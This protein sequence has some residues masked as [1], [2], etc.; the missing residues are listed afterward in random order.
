[1]S[2]R[3]LNLHTFATA[4]V[5]AATAVITL[6]VL[7]WPGVAA[8]PQAPLRIGVIDNHAPF[9]YMDGNERRGFD[10]EVAQAICARMKR[11]CTFVPLHFTLLL[12]SLS[13][14]DVDA[15][16]AGFK[17]TEQR[18]HEYLFSS[19]YYRSRSFFITDDK[20]I[21]DV[22]PINSHDMRIGCVMNSAQDLHLKKV[23]TPFGAKIVSYDTYEDLLAALRAGSID[24]FLTDGL[25]GYALLRQKNARDLYIADF[26]HTS[27]GAFVTKARI[28]VDKNRPD[29][30]REINEALTDLRASE[31]F[32]D[33]AGRYFPNYNNF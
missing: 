28:A 27:G 32:P 24:V 14:H 3:F 30:L 2:N 4:C 19:P 10:V 8:T 13:H 6:A 1:M 25:T 16:V 5:Y 15:V 21:T 12:P 7:H 17:E 33:I 18:A 22:S 9:S 26:F 11:E 23:Y 20:R 29:L 31:E